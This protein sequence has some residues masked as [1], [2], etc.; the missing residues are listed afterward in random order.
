MNACVMEVWEQ[1]TDIGRRECVGKRA[2]LTTPHGTVGE[3]KPSPAERT[4][5]PPKGV[6]LP[7]VCAISQYVAHAFGIVYENGPEAPTLVSLEERIKSVI[8]PDR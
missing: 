3:E 7:V 1:N 4:Q 5:K 8:G 6:G 2:A